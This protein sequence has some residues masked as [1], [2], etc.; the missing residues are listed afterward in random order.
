MSEQL[1]DQEVKDGFYMV[2]LAEICAD[3]DKEQIASLRRERDE[4]SED[5]LVAKADQFKL[6]VDIKNA[7]NVLSDAYMRRLKT[8][9]AITGLAYLICD[10]DSEIEELEKK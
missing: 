9:V 2:S 7:E 8:E 6:N 4:W 3:A 5:L 1:S 10:V